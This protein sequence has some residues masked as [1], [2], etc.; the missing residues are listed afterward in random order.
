MGANLDLHEVKLQIQST[1]N[2]VHLGL[3]GG[4]ASGKTTIAEMFRECGIHIYSVIKLIDFDILARDVVEPGTKALA[5]VAACFGPHILDPSGCLDRKALSGIIFKYPLKRKQLEDILHPAIFELFCRKVAAIVQK[6]PEAVII[7]VIPLLIEM[8]LQPL[9]DR[10]IVVHVSPKIQ[11]KRL[12]QRDQIDE[13]T[14]LKIM[15]SQLLID[16]KLKY[17]DFVV[18]NSNSLEHS[19]SQVEAIWDECTL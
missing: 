5:D 9:F 8:N 3:T 4:I 12:M 14:A 11:L 10:I 13:Q 7:S 6:E 19:R 16:E 2:P 1:G 15:N 18:D 17:A